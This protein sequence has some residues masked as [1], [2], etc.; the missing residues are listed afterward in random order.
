MKLKRFE[1][2][3][4]EGKEDVLNSLDDKL[5]NILQNNNDSLFNRLINMDPTSNLESDRIGGYTKWLIKLLKKS[6]RILLDVIKH[7][8]DDYRIKE[9]IEF[10]HKNKSK[11]SEKDINKYS[12]IMELEN[13]ISKFDEVASNTIK[14]SDK[15]KHYLELANDKEIEIVGENLNYL[16]IIPLNEFISNTIAGTK[17][18][19]CTARSS[20]SFFNE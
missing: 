5:K 2:F 1:N 6:D 4:N 13:V 11:F 7:P 18:K 8:E 12:S 19:W 20:G 16:V 9:T 14:N 3:L 17:T 10:F 15:Y